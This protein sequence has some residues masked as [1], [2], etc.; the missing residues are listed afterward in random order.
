[1]LSVSITML[2]LDPQAERG[3]RPDP[4]GAEESQ[5][6]GQDGSRR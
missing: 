1:M 3:V 4:Q 6:G 2:L 5:R